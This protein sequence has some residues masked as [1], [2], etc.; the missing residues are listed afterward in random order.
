MTGTSSPEFISLKLDRIAT[1]ARQAPEMVFTTLAHHVDANFL[2]EAY[3]RTRKDAAV[4]VDGQTAQAFE[5]DLQDNLQCLVDGLKSGSYKAPPVRRVY[6]PKASGGQR[7]LGVPT[8]A[9]KVLQRGVTMLLEAVYEQDFL[10][11]SYGFRP[12]RSAHQALAALR[13]G[14]MRMRGGWVLEVDIERF[15]DTLDHSHLR[16][17]LDQ[18]VRDGVLR[19]MINKW[20]KAGVLE[21]DAVKRATSGSPQGAVISP[22]LANV[23]LHEVLDT[24]FAKTVKPRLQGDA[25]LVRYADLCGHPHKSAYA[26]FRIMPSCCRDLCVAGGLRVESS[27]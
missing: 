27:A 10:D 21:Q 1:L 18:R 17:F 2:A 19:R 6:I 20:L 3:R 25:Q 5:Q 13:D 12:G 15:F 7:A 24:W 22:L 23:Y 26:E 4:G 11:C 9:D 14:L 8:F 16:A